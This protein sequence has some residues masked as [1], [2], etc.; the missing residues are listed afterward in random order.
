MRYRCSILLL[1]LLGMI[2]CVGTVRAQEQ[3]EISGTVMSADDNAPLPGANVSVPG[4]TIGTATGAQGQYSLQVPSDADSLRFSFVGFQAQTVAIA[5]RTTVDVALLP[6][7]QQIEEL[8]VVGYGTQEEQDVTG[9][10]QKVNPAEFNEGPVVSPEQ[11]ISGKV[12]GV[13]IQATSG[14]PGASSFAR[15]RG[16]SSVNADSSPLFVV[17]GVPLSNVGNQASRNPLNFLNPNDIANVTVLKDASATAIYG[18]RGANGVIMIETKSA[19]EGQGRI[20]YSGSASQASIVDRIDVLEADEFRR[21]VRQQA[22]EQ[23][24]LLGDTETDWQ[25]LTQRTGYTQEHNL[26]FARGY[27][28]SNIRLSLSFLDQKGTL[29]TSSTRRVSASIRYNQ[30]F[31]EDQLSITS[32]LRGSKVDNSFEPGIVGDAASFAPTQPVRDLDSPFGGFFEWSQPGL[33]LAR[34]NPVASYVLT[35]NDGESYRSLGNVE[36]DYEIPYVDGLN[37]RVKVGYDITS[38]EREFFQ[39]TNLKGQQEGSNPGQLERR[40]FTQLSTLLDAFLEYNGTFDAIN[41][42]LD[43]TAGYSWQEQHEEYPE[44][45]A[46]GLSTNIFGANSTAV[47]TDLE[48]TSPFVTEIPKRLISGFARVNY[49]LLNRYLLTFTVRRD[50]S[51]RFGPENRW[52][53]FPSAALGWRPHN[54]PALQSLFEGALSTLKVRASWG[55]TGNQEIGNFLYAPLYSPGASTVQYQFGE[56]FV[57]TVRPSAADETLKW[58]ETTS[59]NIGVD[60]GLF[61]GRL[62]GA[63]DYYVKRTDD[64]IFP[65]TVP[66]GANLSDV[67]TTNVGSMRNR[68]FE[69]SVDAQIV[70][71][72][73]LSY[74]A[75]FNVSTNKNEVLDVA[76]AGGQVLTGS[77][78][79]GTGQQI[80]II[81]EGEPLNSFFVYEHKTNDEGDP[82]RDGVDHNGDGTVDLLDMYVDQQPEEEEGHGVINADD[83][84]V[85][86]SPRPDWSI[87]HTSRLTY[88]DF[89]L[90]FTLQAELGKHV[91]N[92]VASDMGHYSRLSSFAPSNLHESVKT[93]N[94]TNAQLFSDYYVESASNLRLSNLTLGYTLPTEGISAIDRLRVYGT[95][96]NAF[97]L[98]EYSGA[99]PLAIGIDNNLYP[100]SRTF[101][102]GVNLQL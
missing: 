81:K 8:V 54:E 84:V 82:L 69:F 5:G 12:A 45:T 13:Q 68:G 35:E 2:L 58:E 27:E 101:T 7:A 25:D 40:N 16:A 67:V 28:D 85:G 49:R 70:N 9:S 36:T 24:S 98:T 65:A 56:E 87:G 95:V 48:N 41:S 23:L 83:R 73:D 31:L 96:Q 26:S 100:R 53:T 80:Q 22:P 19:D 62:T 17:D 21:A 51:S 92:N 72:E 57:G 37:A 30:N 61:D 97:I 18:A 4:T 50:G 89:D 74:N 42:E 94:F 47:V 88:G 11:L 75:Q 99:S 20:S 14:A 86:E 52:G 91:Y 66:R 77:I 90:N 102:A 64:L 59:W 34:N 55:V 38:G 32:N 76:A 93:T 60:Y 33:D 29:E 10:V 3:Q 15:I 79:G 6:Q 39:P 1:T 71:T 46:Q 78:A 43:V 44:F 63:L